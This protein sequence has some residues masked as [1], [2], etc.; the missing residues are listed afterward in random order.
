MERDAPVSRTESNIKKK[1]D[2]R[3]EEWHT[4]EE[5]YKS[6]LGVI[7]TTDENNQ[8]RETSER[9]EIISETRRRGEVSPSLK[10]PRFLNLTWD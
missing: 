9:K 6:Q 1:R 2:Q 7:E 10:T 8:R 5:K 4:E 3:K